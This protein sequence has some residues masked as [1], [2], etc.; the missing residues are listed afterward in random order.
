[1]R[2]ATEVFSEWAGNGKD[3]GMERG[4]AASVEEMLNLACYRGVQ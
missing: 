1:M 3:E 4:H 2:D